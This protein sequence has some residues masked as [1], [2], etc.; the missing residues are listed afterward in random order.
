MKG[1]IVYCGTSPCSFPFNIPCC[2]G[3]MDFCFKV[4]NGLS[5]IVAKQTLML[6]RGIRAGDLI[7]FEDDSFF[8][9]DGSLWFNML[10]EEAIVYQQRANRN[11]PLLPIVLSQTLKHLSKRN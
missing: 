3:K 4:S 10:R 6:E 11:P 1:I 2:V 9:F 8:L 7:L 5:D